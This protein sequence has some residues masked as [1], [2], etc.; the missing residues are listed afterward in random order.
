M[1]SA[2]QRIAFMMDA[3]QVDVAPILKPG[4]LR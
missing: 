3:E 1:L 4:E 2:L